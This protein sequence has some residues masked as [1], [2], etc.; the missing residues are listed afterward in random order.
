[1]STISW[2][3]LDTCTKQTWI[4][5][6]GFSVAALQN[7]GKI[8]CTGLYRRQVPFRIQEDIGITFGETEMQSEHQFILVVAIQLKVYVSVNSKHY[9]P[10]G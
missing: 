3:P 8:I 4:N 5:F 6:A 9:H 10:L 7:G 1:M 2:K